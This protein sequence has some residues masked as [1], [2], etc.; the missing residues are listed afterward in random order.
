MGQENVKQLNVEVNECLLG[1]LSP[2]FC[3]DMRGA[4][5]LQILHKKAREVI[6]YWFQ[7]LRVFTKRNSVNC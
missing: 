2:S 3:F 7:N 4:F 6:E 1:I 5:I